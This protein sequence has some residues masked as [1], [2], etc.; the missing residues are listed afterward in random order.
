VA[1]L[2]KLTII[3]NLGADPEMRYTPSGKAV[4]NL[5]VATNRRWPDQS[6]DGGWAEESIW[7]TV[8]TWDQQAERNAEQLKKGDQVYVEG[9]LKPLRLYTRQDGT[10]GGQF[11]ID[12]RVLLKLGKSERN[13][14]AAEYVAPQEREPRPSDNLDV[15]DIPF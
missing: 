15:D 10:V 8:T 13:G 9:R 3:G 6:V 11:E 7:F 4:T 12:A 5:R 1:S 14:D 2:N